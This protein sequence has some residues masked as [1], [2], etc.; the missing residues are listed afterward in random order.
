MLLYVIPFVLLLVVAIVLKKREDANKENTS[1]NNKKSNHKK[2]S[3]KN[4]ARTARTSQKQHTTVVE[5]EVVVKQA[6]KP[7]SP[8][9]K[10]NIERLIEEKNYFSAEAK[11]NQVL[12]QDNAQHELYLYLLDVHLAQKR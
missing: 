1:T 2:T 3:K 10:K 11:I 7:L 9:L 4:V 12:N 5:N 8:E 6:T